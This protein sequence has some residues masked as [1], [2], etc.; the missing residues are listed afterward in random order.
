MRARLRKD[1]ACGD[2]RGVIENT[3]PEEKDRFEFALYVRPA[4]AAWANAL[5]HKIM[6][7][8]DSARNSLI[9]YRDRLQ[10]S[11]RLG[12]SP[13]YVPRRLGLLHAVLGE[14]ETSMDQFDQLRKRAEENPNSANRPANH[15]D[16]DVDRA[17][18]LGWLGRKDEAVAELDRLI[19][20]PT[21]LN[22]HLMRHCLDFW[23]L[24][25]H[26]GCQAILDHPANNRQ[27]PDEKL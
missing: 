14:E 5:A 15:L 8:D 6:G 24:R 11:S 9:D 4:E 3:S 27:L 23:P 16:R 22:V 1:W 21:N 17:I 13:S 20:E 7:D 19:K 10:A 12:N 26:P 25:D 2:A 18:A